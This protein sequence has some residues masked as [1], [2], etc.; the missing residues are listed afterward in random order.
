MDIDIERAQETAK[1]LRVEFADEDLTAVWTGA[2][3]E[4]LSMFPPVVD[5]LAKLRAFILRKMTNEIANDRGLGPRTIASDPASREILK[6]CEEEAIKRLRRE[7][8]WG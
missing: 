7:G 6:K 4:A 8:V 5:N 3:I 2:K 1:Q